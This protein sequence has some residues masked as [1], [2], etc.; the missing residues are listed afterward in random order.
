MGRYCLIVAL[1][2]PL[3]YGCAEGTSDVVEVGE[4]DFS[5]P[6]LGR[7]DMQMLPPPPMDAGM[8]IIP[9]VDAG[10]PVG[11]AMDAAPMGPMGDPA[12]ESLADCL[13][14]C[15]TG[16]CAQM[17]REMAPAESSARYDAIFACGRDQGCGEPGGG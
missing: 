15:N 9:V 8:E 17:C 10:D 5:A 6:V 11:P 7:R 13:S 2:W 16:P 12:C 3:A 4:P 14:A 1:T